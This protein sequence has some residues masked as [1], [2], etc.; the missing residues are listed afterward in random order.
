MNITPIIVP[1][2]WSGAKTCFC[3]PLLECSSAGTPLVAYGED[4][5]QQTSYVLQSDIR[6]DNQVLEI[7]NTAIE[8]LK[9]RKS[10]KSCELGVK[11]SGGLAPYYMRCVDDL[12]ASDILNK[13]FLKKIHED[14]ESEVLFVSIPNKS[15]LL[16]GTNQDDIASFAEDHFLDSE[17]MASTPLT[18][19]VFKVI[20]GKIVE[21]ASARDKDFYETSLIPRAQMF[22]DGKGG[23]LQI[24]VY[25]VNSQLLLK[26]VTLA[27]DAYSHVFSEN[28]QFGG[29]IY[30][31][32]LMEE[33]SD[34]AKESLK[35]I[36]DR[37][38]SFIDSQNLR[39]LNNDEIN[40][41]LEAEVLSSDDE[42]MEQL[43]SPQSEDD[44]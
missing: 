40:I 23:A 10:L 19:N 26:R 1:H 35:K 33:V 11:I 12:T 41:F 32:I 15:T 38:Q 2:D 37:I 42:N 24:P 3:H 13:D 9:K 43:F 16:I 27:L 14:L 4:T 29:N 34:Q 8:N 25:F 5:P 18:A 17:K 22:L 31:Q 30:F 6:S 20:D 44:R 7:Q 39:T 21:T 28:D 36:E